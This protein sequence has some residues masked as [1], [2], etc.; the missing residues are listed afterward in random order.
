MKVRISEG[1]A[2]LPEGD[3]GHYLN[4]YIE[5]NAAVYG[6]RCILGRQPVRTGTVNAKSAHY[7]AELERMAG[8]GSYP[9]VIKDYLQAA[10][11][12]K[13]PAWNDPARAAYNAAYQRLHDWAEGLPTI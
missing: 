9:P 4:I 13:S 8:S 3:R 1:Y 12:L 5:S 10:E 11:A 7:Y 6:I 2:M